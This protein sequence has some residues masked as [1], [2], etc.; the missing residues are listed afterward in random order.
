M[1]QHSFPSTWDVSEAQPWL[2][3]LPHRGSGE[4]SLKVKL[5]L[6]KQRSVAFNEPRQMSY[7]TPS[8]RQGSV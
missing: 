4:V 5:T 7:S 6:E 8:S 3:F 1:P 2:S